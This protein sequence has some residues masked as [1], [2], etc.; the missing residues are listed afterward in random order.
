MAEKM[1]RYSKWSDSFFKYSVG[2]QWRQEWREK[3]EETTGAER[4]ETG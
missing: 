2:K 3:Q 4:E 1:Q